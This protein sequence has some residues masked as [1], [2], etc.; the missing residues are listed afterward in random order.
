MAKS[1]A[2]GGDFAAQNAAAIRAVHSLH[3][4]L[5]AKEVRAA[6]YAEC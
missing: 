3:P 4:Y 1:K 6:V 2:A 5:T